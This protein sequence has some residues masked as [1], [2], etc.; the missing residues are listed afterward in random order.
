[1]K[2]IN[3]KERKPDNWDKK[4]VRIISNKKLI[5]DPSIFNDNHPFD[6]NYDDIEWLDENDDITDIGLR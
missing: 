5:S 3:A 4:I 2:W 1:M 6:I